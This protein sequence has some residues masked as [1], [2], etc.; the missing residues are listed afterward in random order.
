MQ[1]FAAL[2]L[3]ITRVRSIAA[4]NMRDLDIQFQT[5]PKILCEQSRLQGEVDMRHKAV[6]RSDAVYRETTIPLKKGASNARTHTSRSRPSS[7]RS[8]N[9]E[10]VGFK[11]AKP[12]FFSGVVAVPR[13]CVS[14]IRGW[15]RSP[16]SFDRRHMFAPRCVRA[17]HARRA[18]EQWAKK[19]GRG[20]D[21]T[22]AQ[23]TR[24]ARDTHV[25]ERLGL[26]GVVRGLDGAWE[27]RWRTQ[28]GP[29]STSLKARL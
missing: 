24:I 8:G 12:H 9:D 14:A 13:R 3:R 6:T 28:S 11:Q 22:E 16:S 2:S 17:I 27:Q 21:F 7:V 10:R 26:H 15:A 19:V 29:A 20:V 1:I 23:L 4:S 5:I 25:A 18:I